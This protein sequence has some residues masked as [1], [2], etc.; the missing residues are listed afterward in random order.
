MGYEKGLDKQVVIDSLKAGAV[1]IGAPSYGWS[2]WIKRG[3][4]NRQGG[5]AIENDML[6]EL[7]RE[8][9][10]SMERTGGSFHCVFCWN[11]SRGRGK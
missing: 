11:T 9:L 1:I 2:L 8:G 6:S 5:E 7:L 4:G 10:I 3:W